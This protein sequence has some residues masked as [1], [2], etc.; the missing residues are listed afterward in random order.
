GRYAYSAV[1]PAFCAP[2]MRKSG[3]GR[4]ADVARPYAQTTFR[5]TTRAG[6]GIVGIN[7]ARNLIRPTTLHQRR[8]KSGRPRSEEDT[9]DQRHSASR[10]RQTRRSASE[11]L[12]VEDS[13]EQVD[14][15]R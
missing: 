10:A 4:A 6:A 8:R 2:M 1:V 14:R 9:W 11:G 7:S 3:N 15:Q 5:A 12:C 13:R